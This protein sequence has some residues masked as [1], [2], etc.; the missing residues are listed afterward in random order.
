MLIPGLVHRVAKSFEDSGWKVF[1]Q[2]YFGYANR[3]G[4]SSYEVQHG[5]GMIRGEK[6]ADDA[7]TRFQNH[8]A[9][10]FDA[11]TE[12]PDHY[13]SVYGRVFLSRTF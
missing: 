7:E 5:G 9:L 3:S 4:E 13:S 8:T 1:A 12:L 10:S 11:G 6:A 2:P